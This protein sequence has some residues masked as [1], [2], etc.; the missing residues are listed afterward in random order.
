MEQGAATPTLRREAGGDHGHDLVELAALEIPVRMRAAHQLEQRIL[1]PLLRGRLRDDLL[2][3]HVERLARNDQM[4][5]L[6]RVHA[7]QECRAFDEIVT[8][9]RE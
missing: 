4:I 2:R 7:A 9:E 3:E 8:G 5:E 1:L 6:P